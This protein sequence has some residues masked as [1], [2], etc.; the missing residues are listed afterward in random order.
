MAMHQSFLRYRD[1]RYL[2][3]A[4][5]LTLA[6]IVAY[7]VHRPYDPPNGGTWLGYTLGT[8]G[9]LLILWLLWFG[10]RKRQY[11][12]NAGLVNAWLSGHVYLGAS[13]IFV[14]TLHCGFQFGWNVHT[15]AYVLTMV[16][17]LSGFYG[18]WAY[19]FYPTA[20]TK[21][22]GSI[23]RDAM[24]A[25][26][27]E[28]DRESLQL[29]D[30]VGREAHGVVLKSIEE[31][32]LGGNWSEQLFGDPAKRASGGKAS[33]GLEELQ[34]R[35]E[36]RIRRAED[37]SVEKAVDM[38]A[39]AMGFLAGQL[40]GGA[41]RLEKVRRLLD[42]IQRKRTLVETVQRDIQHHARMA[43]WLYLHVPLSIGLLAA[44][45]AHVITVFLYW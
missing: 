2:K 23:T 18:I 36:S 34:K 3:M 16:V 9:A 19:A 15:L 6:S 38:E 35:I 29:A 31:T 30:Q 42:L 13:L 24:L 26:I 41:E 39:T 27:A 28:L 12:S 17:V 10:V 21:N 44:L 7:V 8:I 5:A 1:F 40:E 11:Q 45:T 14:A 43:V 20:I 25:E 22:R 33:S 32:R 4:L 37:A